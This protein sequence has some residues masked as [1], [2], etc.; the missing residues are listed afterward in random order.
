MEQ[1]ITGLVEAGEV[2]GILHQ[3]VE[4]MEALVVEEA[5]AMPLEQAAQ[6][7]LEEQV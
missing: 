7:A 1:D 2:L 3:V 5:V 6:G 4:V